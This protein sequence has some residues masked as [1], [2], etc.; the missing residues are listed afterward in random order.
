MGSACQQALE[1]RQNVMTPNDAAHSANLYYILSLLTDGEALD[2]AQNSPVSNGMEVRRRMVTHWDPKLPSR[3]RG[4]LQAIWFPMGQSWRRR[5]T[6]GYSIGKATA[7][8]RTAAA[9]KLGVVLH[10]LPD[11]PLR[12]NTCFIK[13]TFVRHVHLDANSGHGKNDVA[14]PIA[15]GSER[16]LSHVLEEWSL[17]E[18]LLV[19]SQKKE[20]ARARMAR[21]ARNG[22][23]R[24]PNP[25]MAT[26]RRKKETNNASSSGGGDVLC[27]TYTD[28]QFQWIMMLPEVGQICEQTSNMRF[29]VDSGA[30][31]HARPL[32]GEPGSSQGGTFLTAT[33]APVE[34][35]VRWKFNSSWLMCT[36][37][38]NCEAH[39]RVACCASSDFE[40]GGQGLLS[41][42]EVS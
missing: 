36:V 6:V 28:D 31:C 35:W 39:V 8:L 11:A 21:K 15:D 34:S 9:I 25:R 33:G 26:P 37:T 3:F 13:L 16:M 4:M 24:A 2:I 20:V 42:W 40:C 17:C 27:M 29:L 41:S 38:S 23:A 1:F 32:Q 5:D 22:K 14:R 19:P 7:G 18:R 10:H 12:D 30:A